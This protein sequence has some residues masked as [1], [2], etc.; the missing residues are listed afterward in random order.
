[1]QIAYIPSENVLPHTRVP[2][3]PTAPQRFNRVYTVS[4]AERGLIHIG[5]NAGCLIIRATRG[6]ACKKNAGLAYI[7][8][9]ANVN[10]EGTRP[11][12][13]GACRKYCFFLTYAKKV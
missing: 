6:A 13:E 11:V 5:V 3:S 7:P 2:R 12:G 1:M 4:L 9:D 10:S 8:Q